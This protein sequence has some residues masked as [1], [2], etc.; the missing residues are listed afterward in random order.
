VGRSQENLDADKSK[1][2]LCKAFSNTGH[3]FLHEMMHIKVMFRAP[4]G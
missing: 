1:Q 4:P 3:I 2:T